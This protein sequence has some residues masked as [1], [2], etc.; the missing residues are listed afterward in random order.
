[1]LSIKALSS[2]DTPTIITYISATLPPP[3]LTNRFAMASMTPASVMPSITMNR[4]ASSSRVLKSM[5][6][7][8]LTATSEPFCRIAS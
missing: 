2:T 6:L 7:I 1:M 3:A 4:P 5:D 8:T